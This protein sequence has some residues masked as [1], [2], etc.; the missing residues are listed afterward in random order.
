VN[1][2]QRRIAE[3]GRLLLFLDYDGTLVRINKAPQNAVLHPARRNFLKRLSQRA[4]VCI[5][6]GRSLD[7]V[8]QLVALENIAYIGNHGLELSWGQKS[9]VHP[10]ATKSRAA[11]AMLLSRIE[12]TTACFPRLMIEDK[13]IT[14]SIHFRGMDPTLVPNVQKTVKDAVHQS[15]RRFLLTE[16]KKVLEIRPNLDWDKGK[17][18]KKLR[19]W[20]PR[21][22][23]PIIVYI[24]DDRT[25]EDAFQALSRKA[26]TTRV[27][28][29]K[30][31]L[32]RYRI[33]NV[34]Q[35][36]DLLKA[37]QR[38]LKSMK[39]FPPRPPLPRPSAPHEL[40][41]MAP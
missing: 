9:W 38:S 41:A 7:D 22:D 14:A 25:D 39:S 10:Q 21:D 32:A 34:D 2:I 6:T 37:M 17:G 16:G 5:V 15:R 24:G 33:A 26:V 31:S 8:K 4:F 30:D 36:W 3:G 29:K 13:G 19:R 27:G 20:I 1:D 28:R 18:I 40:Q 35:V 11:L 23:N 12:K